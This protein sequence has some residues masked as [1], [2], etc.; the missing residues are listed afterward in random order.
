MGRY[1]LAVEVVRCED[2]RLFASLEE[3]SLAE[4]ERMRRCDGRVL[5]SA[6]REVGDDGIV[7]RLCTE[8]C[9]RVEEIGN[10]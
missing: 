4:K 3:A 8:D 10:A 1:C 2:V 9:L 7:R 5:G 6:V